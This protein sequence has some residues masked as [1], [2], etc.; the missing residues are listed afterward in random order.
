MATA[1]GTSSGRGPVLVAAAATAAAAGLVA[2]DIGA[3]S[4]W[5]DEAFTVGLVDRPLGDAL[6]RIGN[7]ELIQSPY[8]V[9][10]LAWHELGSSEAFLRL[11]SA[12]F[13]VTTVPVVFALGRRLAD[14]WTGAVAAAVVAGHS[15]VV[16]WGQQLRAY[17]LATLLVALA[18]LLLVR[19]VERPTTGR[20]VAYAAVAALA[21]YAHVVAALVVV[22]HALSLVVLRPVPWRVVKVAALTGAVLVAPLAW[23]VL[24]RQGDPLDHIGEPS[25][26]ELVSTLADIAGGGTRHLV[27]LGG[28]AV[29]GA[30][31]A[32]GVT[33]RRPG[34][35][36]AWRA[37]L[38]VLWLLVPVVAVVG[39][40]YTVK[41]LLL[42]RY[43]V[44]VVPALALL[45]AVAVRRLPRAVAAVALVAVAVVSLQGVADWYE[46]GS[47]ED[48]RTAVASVEGSARPGDQVVVLPG[49]AVAAVRYYGPELRTLSPG[50]LG[51]AT[52]DRLWLI[53]RLSQ[54]GPGP[55]APPGFD[56]RL[57]EGY[58]LVE[59]RRFTNLD[60]RLY[61]R[62]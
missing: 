11:L 43:L 10:F 57:A 16:Q 5:Y 50:N 13:A 3:K 27:V 55:S 60:V 15:L 8:Y 22:A 9:A 25:G 44:V 37:A 62:P 18:T 28:L 19:A 14:P 6:W 51:A 26:P 31:V 45:V 53:D 42:A 48:W 17:S 32:A 33:R 38:P 46:V 1:T 41:P 23:F 36:E 58:V 59:E 61:E 49:R 24:T 7:W 21:A 34:S 4:L 40:T 29:V 30:V 52:G 35:P 20:S 39:S 47:F 2:H 56:E 54:R 12:G